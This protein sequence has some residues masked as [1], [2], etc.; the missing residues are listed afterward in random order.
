MLPRAQ[1]K[2]HVLED[3]Q[4]REDRVV[5]EHHAEAALLRRQQRD[6]LAVDGNQ[7]FVD[8]DEAGDHHQRRRLAGARR[9]QQGE[10]LA[11]TDRNV[12]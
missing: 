1:R 5:L 10:E 3:V 8:V 12:D 9:T 7:P 11:R 4:V 6:V 2:G